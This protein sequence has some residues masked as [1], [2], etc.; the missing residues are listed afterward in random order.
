MLTDCRFSVW[1]GLSTCWP[2]FSLVLTDWATFSKV[3]L[4]YG[5]G[6]TQSVMFDDPVVFFARNELLCHYFHRQLN[7]IPY[8]MKWIPSASVVPTTSTTQSNQ[9]TGEETEK[10]WITSKTR[11]ENRQKMNWF[12]WLGDGLQLLLI[13]S[14]I[15]ELLSNV[16]KGLKQSQFPTTHRKNWIPTKKKKQH[17]IR[18]RVEWLNWLL[19][20]L[21]FLV[22]VVFLLLFCLNL[23]EI[24]TSTYISFEAV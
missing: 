23:W 9:Y 2:I 7:Y 8:N 17:Q 14:L 11:A 3:S 10:R 5:A 19:C 20:L 4:F 12:S 18:K 15:W 21:A 6:K 16:T 1:N 13:L 22:R 24:W